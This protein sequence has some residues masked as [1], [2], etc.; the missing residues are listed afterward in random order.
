VY[1]GAL[2]EADE[3]LVRHLRR[4]TPYIGRFGLLVLELTLPPATAAGSLDRTP[5]IAYD[6]THGYSDQLPGRSLGVPA[7]CA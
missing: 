3:N 1:R 5:A 7:V 6:A 2:L 4:W